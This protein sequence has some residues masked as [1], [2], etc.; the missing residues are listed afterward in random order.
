MFSFAFFVTIL[1]N[2]IPEYVQSN[3][4]NSIDN[5]AIATEVL[6]LLRRAVEIE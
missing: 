5:V 4:L 2:L 3:A 1:H 6:Q